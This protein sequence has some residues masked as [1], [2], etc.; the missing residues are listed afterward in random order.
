MEKMFK[1][2]ETRKSFPT[3]K[4]EEPPPPPQN[5]GR[6]SADFLMFCK[7]VLDYEN[8]SGADSDSEDLR[9]RHTSSPLGSTG[10]TGGESNSSQEGDTS[11]SREQ[12]RGRDQDISEDESDDES[13]GITC[14]CGKPYA[15]RPMIECS[16]CATW[17]HLACA[18]VKR[19]AIPDVWYCAVCK[20]QPANATAKGLKGKGTKGQSR[21]ISKPSNKLSTSSTTSSEANLLGLRSSSSTSKR[22]S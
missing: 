21:K 11:F 7:M 6:S 16:A 20:R 19:T 17:V 13:T 15:G 9:M 18:R 12:H 10:S 4:D 1:T 14:Y 2:P 5:R 3:S 22:K 8:Y